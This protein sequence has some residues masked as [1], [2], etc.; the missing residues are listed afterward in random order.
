MNKHLFPGS[1]GE[2][3]LQEKYGTEKRAEAFYQNQVLNELNS[4][5]MKFISNQEMVFISTAD[6][7]GECDCSFRFGTA[8]FVHVVDSHTVLYPEYRGN[9]VMASLGN[10]VENPNIGLMF[11]DFF[12]HTIGLHVNGKAR[13]IENETL[14][15]LQNVPLGLKESQSNPS[16]RRPERWVKIEVEEAYIHCSKH[17]PL[18]QKLDK[19]IH[20][21]TDSDLHKGGDFFGAKREISPS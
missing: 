18:L 13:I 19:E 20:W 15:S 2:H 4:D 8:G 12:R 1:D 10:L 17:I 5:M 7:K 3:R 14:L 16:L 11:I 9:G 6:K 21:D